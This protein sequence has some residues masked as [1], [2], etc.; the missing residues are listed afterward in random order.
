LNEILDESVIA[1]P[2]ADITTQG[3]GEGADPAFESIVR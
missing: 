1:D 3:A 2:S